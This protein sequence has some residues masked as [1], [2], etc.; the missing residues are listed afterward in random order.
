[1]KFKD[2]RSSTIKGQAKSVHVYTDGHRMVK[3][4]LC[5]DDVRGIASGVRISENVE[6]PFTFADIRT[7]GANHAPGLNHSALLTPCS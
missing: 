3:R 1:M 7:T 6:R 2:G 4:A 5:S